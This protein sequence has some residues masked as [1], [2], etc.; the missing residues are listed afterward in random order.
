LSKNLFGKFQVQD[1]RKFFIAYKDDSGQDLASHLHRA[2]H[3]RGVDVFF[4]KT[5]L[6]NDLSFGEWD[7]QR[8]K[9]VRE[10]GIL[11][12][13]VTDGLNLSKEV[14]KE[15]RIAIKHR[16]KI[17]VFVENSLKDDEQQLI[18]QLYPKRKINLKK[19]QTDFFTTPEDLLRAVT[20]TIPF[21]RVTK[22]T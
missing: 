1:P 7:R 18:I 13:I 15:L 3:D 9:A 21:T 20:R 4:A 5:D 6:K 2:L 10:C 19:Y 12:L 14:R 22:L 8:N 11:I 17:T 16:K